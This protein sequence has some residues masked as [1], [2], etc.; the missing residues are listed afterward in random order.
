LVA[1]AQGIS[2]GATSSEAKSATGVLNF[3][4]ELNSTI[5]ISLTATGRPTLNK[6][7]SGTASNVPFILTD[8]DLTSL[9]TGSISMSATATDVAGNTSL[10][11]LIS[12]NI[13]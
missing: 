8:A 6:T 10:A 9:G 5:N 12:F 4:A 13:I 7:L 1:L 11:S 2:D 3:W